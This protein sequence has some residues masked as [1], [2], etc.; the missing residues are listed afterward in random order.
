MKFHLYL[1]FAME[2]L[3]H[4]F[5]A[6]ELLHLYPL[7]LFAVFAFLASTSYHVTHV[8]LCTNVCTKEIQPILSCHLFILTFTFWY[9]TSF[10]YYRPPFPR[11]HRLLCEGYR[12]LYMSGGGQ[13][14]L[15][16]PSSIQVFVLFCGETKTLTLAPTSTVAQLLLALETHLQ[17]NLAD[18]GFYLTYCSKNIGYDRAHLLLS[19]FAI[20]QNSTL[21]LQPRGLGGGKRKRTPEQRDADAA[22]QRVRRSKLTEEQRQDDRDNNRVAHATTRASL[23]EEERQDD[24]D[25]NRVAHATTRA[26]LTEEELSPRRQADRVAHAAMPG[27]PHGGRTISPPSSRPGGARRE[28]IKVPPK[29]PSISQSDLECSQSA[30]DIGY[31][32]HGGK[33]GGYGLFAQHLIASGSRIIEY[34]GRVVTPSMEHQET[35]ERSK[36]RKIS[37]SNATNSYLMAIRDGSLLIDARDMGNNARFC[38]HCT[39][40]QNPNVV[41]E[42][43]ETDTGP[44]VFLL[45]TQRIKAGQ[46]LFFT[47][48]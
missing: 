41:A 30:V 16:S 7:A 1:F 19:D 14:S 25:N 33:H 39:A 26:S 29:R 35:L 31:S 22:S 17:I 2:L 4:H 32:V 46:E 28:P 10:F 9:L 47:Y 36:R 48:N 45:A 43:V 37:P 40:D 24:R 42:E 8:L 38:N 15:S 3:L 12:C 13:P 11:R 21:H 23:T 6:M 20:C 44:R 27:R 34:L 18:D 5:F